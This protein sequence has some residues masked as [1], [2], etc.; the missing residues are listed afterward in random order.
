MSF[1]DTTLTKNFETST[2][3]S[4]AFDSYVPSH[5]LEKRFLKEL[6]NSHIAWRS[7]IGP[8]NFSTYCFAD[9]LKKPH[10]IKM[11]THKAIVL[12]SKKCSSSSK[13]C[14]AST[15]KPSLTIR[16]G[17]SALGVLPKTHRIGEKPYTMCSTDDTL[18]PISDPFIA[19]VMIPQLQEGD[20]NGFKERFKLKI[21]ITEQTC[22]IVTANSCTSTIR[23]FKIPPNKDH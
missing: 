23:G 6:L 20:V 8:V 4:G 17:K 11:D 14:S 5:S 12:S 16:V 21:K 22:P 7:E 15:E 1:S 13:P 2:F 9:H 18:R 10:P 19:G 3:G